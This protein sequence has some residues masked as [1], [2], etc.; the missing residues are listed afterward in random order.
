MIVYFHI[1]FNKILAV[2]FKSVTNLALNKE[3]GNWEEE[4]P[5]IWIW[6]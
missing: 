2:N 5:L 3:E 6:N 1:S 4:D